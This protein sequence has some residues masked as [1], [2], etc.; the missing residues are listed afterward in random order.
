MGSSIVGLLASDLAGSSIVCGALFGAYGAQ[1][2][3]DMIG[4]HTQEV[5]DLAFIP[6]SRGNGYV[7]HDSFLCDS[8]C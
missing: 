4:R 7:Y 6:V 3:A 5:R 1:Y 2:T 8:A